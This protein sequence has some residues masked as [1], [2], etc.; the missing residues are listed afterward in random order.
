MIKPP[1]LAPAKSR[2]IGLSSPPV[3]I[4]PRAGERNGRRRT[5]SESAKLA[6]INA[7]IARYETELADLTRAAAACRELLRDLRVRHGGPE[8]SAS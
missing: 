6:A 5:P 1:T 7:R 8:R 4:D 2:R 3:A